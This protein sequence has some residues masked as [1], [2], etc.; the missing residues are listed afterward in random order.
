[1]ASIKGVWIPEELLE[2]DIS[3]T[4]RILIAEISQLEML[5]MGCIASN[6][7]FANKLK[8]ST[9]AISKAL[10][11]LSKDGY[12]T[13]NNAQTKRN[14]GR[15]ITINFGKSPINFGKSP[16]HQSGESKGKEQ[17]NNTISKGMTSKCFALEDM[18]KIISYRKS[19][20]KQIKTQKGFSSLENKIQE[21][22]STFNVGLDEV[23]EFMAEKEWQSIDVTWK[24]VIARFKQEQERFFI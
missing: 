5:D 22:I 3:W 2:L 16:I 24:E 19:I 1:M 12:I 10:N 18:K 15:T 13:I 6:S 14:F 23:L 4:K 17:D 11:E 20:A 9:Q 21:V 8:L 7:H